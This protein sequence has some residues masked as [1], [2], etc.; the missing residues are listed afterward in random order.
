MYTDVAGKAEPAL[1]TDVRR[2]G[3]VLPLDLRRR[4]QGEPND[5]AQESRGGVSR[6]GVSRGGVWRRGVKRTGWTL[7]VFFCRDE[8]FI[9]SVGFARV[10]SGLCLHSLFWMEFDFG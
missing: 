4:H 5:S 2:R 8:G 10:E 7:W 1:H 6:G 9:Y 3:A